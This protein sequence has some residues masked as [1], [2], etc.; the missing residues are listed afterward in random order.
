MRPFAR[1]VAAAAACA[2][3]L[4]APAAAAAPAR[5]QVVAVEFDFM[6]SRQAIKA[7]PAIVELVNY[8][9]DLHDL[10]LRRIGGTLTRKIPVVR[11]DGERTLSARLVAGRYDLWCSVGDHRA[12]G[13][14]ARLTVRR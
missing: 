12:R 11:P 7:G 13:M 10:R 9:E 2:V 1:L 8:G 4:A 5:L 3:A 6:L 14:R